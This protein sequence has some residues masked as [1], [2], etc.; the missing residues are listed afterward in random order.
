[1]KL[2]SPIYNLLSIT[3]VILIIPS[4]LFGK[5]S[6]DV[7]IY[8]TYF[9]IGVGQFL[10]L[11]SFILLALWMIYK[12]CDNVL[13]SAKLTGIHVIVSVLSIVLVSTSF[14]WGK[15]TLWTPGNR[16]VEPVTPS[17]VAWMANAQGAILI[18]VIAFAVAQLFLIINIIAGLTKRQ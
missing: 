10:K 1:M 16:Y 2:L 6:F 9:I 8:N 11:N 17:A 15:F 4:F 12:L 7:H 5:Q 14:F 18:L 3:A 13:Y